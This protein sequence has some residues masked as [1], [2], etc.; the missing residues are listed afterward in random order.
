MIAGIAGTR[1]VE[2]KTKQ[3]ERFW[4]FDRRTGNKSLRVVDEFIIHPNVIKRQGVGECVVIKKFPVSQAY[5]LR[6]LAPGS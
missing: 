2:E 1:R 3:V 5:Q 6:V 4:F